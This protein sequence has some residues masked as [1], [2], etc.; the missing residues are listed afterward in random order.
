MRDE[1]ADSII[2]VPKDASEINSG[3]QVTVTLLRWGQL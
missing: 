3:E 2:R 1:N